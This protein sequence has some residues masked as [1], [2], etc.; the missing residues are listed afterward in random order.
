MKT[1]DVIITSVCRNTLKRTLESFTDMV[2]YSGSFNF[3][4]NIDVFDDRYLP[5][6]MQYLQSFGIRNINISR[7]LKRGHQAHAKA[8]NYLFAAISTPYYFHLEDDWIFLQKIDLDA[9][10]DLMELHPL[11]HHIRFNKEKTK[12]A[13]WL[14]HIYDEDN[15]QNR[16]I[17][18]ETIVDLI[19]L[20]KVPVW[21]FNPSLGRS[22]IVKSLLP[23]SPDLNPEKSVCFKYDDL[24]YK[25]KGTYI[26]GHIGDKPMVKDIGRNKLIETLRIFKSFIIERL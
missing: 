19:P 14:Y 15:T 12:N 5:Q 18:E 13:S 9:I 3:L 22:A 8:I 4:V 26:Y 20:T 2:R 17:N 24:Y 25:N 1:I 7:P 11:L 10:V 23:L 16:V 21:S 6:I